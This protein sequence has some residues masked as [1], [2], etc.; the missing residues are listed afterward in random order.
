MKKKE[1]F[2]VGGS[3]A[4]TVIFA[5]MAIYTGQEKDLSSFLWLPIALTVGGIIMTIMAVIQS[6]N[7]SAKKE[8]QQNAEKAI[9]HDSSFGNNELKLYFDSSSSKV[10]ICA[11]TTSESKQEEVRDFV[12]SNAVET[13]SYI[14]AV[15]T[16]SRQLCRLLPSLTLVHTLCKA[17]L[18]RE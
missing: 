6:S 14:V 12:R 13:D 3:I 4:M 2:S 11:T 9:K 1:E 18:L 8:Q 7:E 10:T 16:L 15:D 17:L 5:V